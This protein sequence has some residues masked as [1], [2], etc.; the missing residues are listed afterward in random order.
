MPSK[1][2]ILFFTTLIIL[3]GACVEVLFTG[4]QLYTRDGL[5]NI[6]VK[7]TQRPYLLNILQERILTPQKFLLIRYASYAALIVNPVL[8]YIL[9]LRRIAI[10]S[11]LVFVMQ[12]I[13]SSFK[14]VVAT[15][16]Q[17][18]GSANRAFIFLMVLITAR[19]IYYL[20]HFELQYDEMWSYN[21]FTSRPFYISIFSYNNYPLYELSTQLTRWLPFSM[22]VNLRLPGFLAGLLSCTVL[23]ACIKNYTRNAFIA[24][25]G[26]AIFA[27]MPVT[28]FYML[29]ARGVMFELFFAIVSMFSL[30][31]MLRGGSTKKYFT[32]FVIAN[33]AGM[34]S[35]PTHVYFL[36]V[37]GIVALVYVLFYNK[38]LVKPFV[39]NN[40]LVAVGSIICY[41]PVVAG[42]GVSFALHPPAMPGLVNKLLPDLLFYSSNSNTFFTGGPWGLYILLALTMAVVIIFKKRNRATR[43]LIAAAMAFCCLPLAIYF[44]QR[45]GIPE[46]ALAFIGL[47]IPLCC[48]LIFYALKDNFTQ[49]TLTVLLATLTIAGGI[50]SHQ[51][52]FMNWS[53]ETDRKAITISN[54]LMQ[55][56]VTSVYNNA[57]SSKFFYYY[58]AL[59]Y[60]YGFKHQA[61]DVSMSTPNSLRYKPFNAA[62]DYDCVIENVN[63]MPNAALSNYHIL[64]TDEDEGFTILLRNR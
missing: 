9:Y 51:H 2:S 48:C 30:L 40:I 64:Y 38:P 7:L 37:Q 16:R 24:L 56:H 20:V 57:D 47:V 25:A 6:I 61:V 32:L 49:Y 55:Q 21:Y 33:I 4:I 53:A 8:I 29:Y 43:F 18:T 34:Y 59:E 27:C 41:L 1:R 19:A 39:L 62:D 58:P 54:L 63:A 50:I 17:N 42:S 60:Y 10:T 28:T 13:S 52:Y 44:V 3:L 26:T 12:C 45:I 14:A 35:T 5:I 15:F 31:F 22:K 23:Y 11:W 36:I 46:R